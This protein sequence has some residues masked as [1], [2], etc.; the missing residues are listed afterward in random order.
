MWLTHT[1]T[2]RFLR[3]VRSSG[4]LWLSLG[5]SVN[6]FALT[7]DLPGNGA[8][9]VGDIKEVSAVTGDT[10]VSVARRYGLGYVE[11]MEANP[12]LKPEDTL[13][14]SQ[15]VLLPTEFILPNADHR[16]LVINLAELRLYFYKPNTREVMTFPVGIG[17]AGWNTPLGLTNVAW[18]QKDPTWHVSSTIKQA[19]A[20]EGVNLP[21]SVAPG[22]DN[23]LG[24]Y[25]IHL[26]FNAILIHG[27]N[28]PGGIGRRSSSG[29]IR[30]Q[31][32]A[33]ENFFDD[34][35][36]NSPV[37]IVDQPI[38]V[39]WLANTLY[40]EVH[41]PLENDQG[42]HNHAMSDEAYHLVNAA[43]QARPADIDWRAVDTSVEQQRGYPVKIGIGIGA[44][45]TIAVPLNSAALEIKH[46]KGKKT[47]VVHKKKTHKKSSFFNV[48]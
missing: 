10:F 30:L 6:A 14:S 11:L 16:G 32:E 17:R 43:I 4:L 31:P 46:A 28:D 45:P 9:I 24:Q 7:F 29:C 26:G 34:V 18:K 22:P 1:M 2:K 20:L 36:V 42:G 21:D 39:G 23:P 35:M 19:R 25:A 37:M 38:K 40:L 5:F 27:S 48:I 47:S 8:T 13:E 41:E 33:I 12:T 3:A 15:A 44:I